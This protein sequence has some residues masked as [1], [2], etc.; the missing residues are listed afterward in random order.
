[1]VLDKYSQLK[2]SEAG[3]YYIMTTSVMEK[4][5]THVKNASN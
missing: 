5:I 2:I 1:M 3:I 4:N